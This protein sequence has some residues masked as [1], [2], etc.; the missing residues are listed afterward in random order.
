MIDFNGVHYQKALI[1]HAMSFYV[2]YTTA[3]RVL[4]ET[5]AER[6]VKAPI[7]QLALCRTDIH[8]V[9]QLD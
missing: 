7:S 5:L 8:I 9:S 4:G 1:L 6:G 3:Y 2:R